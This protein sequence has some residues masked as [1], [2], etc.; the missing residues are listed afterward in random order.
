[1]LNHD[2]RQIF[3]AF[4]AI[5]FVWSIAC[6]LT[7]VFGQALPSESVALADLSTGLATGGPCEDLGGDPR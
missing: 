5:V 3:I 6:L 7:L 2:T 1:M 4:T